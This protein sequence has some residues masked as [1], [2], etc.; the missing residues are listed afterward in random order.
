MIYLLGTGLNDEKDISIKAAEILKKAKLIVGFKHSLDIPKK[1]GCTA[2]YEELDIYTSL[3][4]KKI[5]ELII[6]MKEK[7]DAVVCVGGSPL[8]F[9]YA[10]KIAQKLEK[11]EYEYVCAPSSIEYLSERTGVV[12]NNLS[13]VSGHNSSDLTETRA[14]CLELL[15]LGRRVG[16]YVKNKED[17][18]KL[19]KMLLINT[20]APEVRI[21]AGFELGTEREKTIEIDVFDLFEYEHGRWILLIVPGEN[22]NG[23]PKFPRNNE[24]K[25]KNIPVSREW[26]RSLVAHSLNIKQGDIIWDLGAGSGATSIWLASLTGCHGKV[27][28]VELKIDRVEKLTENTQSYPN[29]VISYG[30]YCEIVKELPKPDKVHIGGGFYENELTKL[31]DLLPSGTPFTCALATIDSIV[32]MKKIKNIDYDCEMYTRSCSRI[33]GGKTAFVGEH[34]FYLF[35]GVVK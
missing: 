30:N 11:K 33:L 12:L 27:H 35:K 32:L 9:S 24:L 28:A 2:E 6:R 17:I 15:K 1:L 23:S 10:R 3:K 26:S 7:K 31:F 21:Y 19:L 25:T 16:Y 4:S 8:I 14:I 13:I 34:V 20:Q 29:I 5:D 22:T 18:D